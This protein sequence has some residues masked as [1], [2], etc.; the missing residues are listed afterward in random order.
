VAE[1]PWAS[2]RSGRYLGAAGLT[3][4]ALFVVSFLL[5]GGAHSGGV[6]AGHPIPPFAVPLASGNVPGDANVATH[7]NDGA[8]GRRPACT[9]RGPGILN[10]CELYERT[11]LVL[12]LFLQAGECPAIL[13]ELQTLAPS[14]PGVRFAAVAIAGDRAQLRRLVQSH[15]L[16]LPV[17][18]DGEGGALGQLYRVFSCPQLTFVYPGGIAQGKPLQARP[19]PAA[20]RARVAELVALSRA[21]GWRGP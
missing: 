17:G 13:D 19:T 20:L 21:R 3:L 9:V 2:P 8:A 14:F 4:I 11:P 7:P 6:A 16:R 10:I 15:H 12:A 5:T 1:T 18:I